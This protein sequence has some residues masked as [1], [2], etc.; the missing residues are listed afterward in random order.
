MIPGNVRAA[1]LA[2]I[3]GDAVIGGAEFPGMSG[4]MTVVVIRKVFA[5]PLA[6][7]EHG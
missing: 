7:P 6:R 2:P 3:G 1:A 5:E 4:I